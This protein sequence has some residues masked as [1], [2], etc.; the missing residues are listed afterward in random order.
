ML[1]RIGS[2]AAAS[3]AVD[4]LLEC[5]VRIRAFLELARR[6]AE[7]GTEAPASVAEAAARVRR[8][9]TEALP[10]HAE[11]EE[12][13]I[14]PRLRGLDPRVDAELDLMAREHREHERPLSE[15]VT[16]CEH[17]ARAPERLPALA[18]AVAGAAA[19]L[20]R[21]FAAHLA[22]EET[23]IF[24]AMRRLLERETDAA[25]MREIRGRRA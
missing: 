6:L 2:P 9:F 15:L 19:E 8:Y 4:L 1:T 13:S 14:L 12:E 22:R 10:L 21:H 16:A 24:P 17:L 23:V 18:P 7:A 11:D 20:E 5:H 3:D 25:I